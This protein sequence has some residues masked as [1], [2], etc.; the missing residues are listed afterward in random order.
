V[1]H[2]PT[3]GKSYSQD[4]R[5]ESMLGELLECDESSEIATRGCDPCV[6][7]SQGADKSRM[8]T[9][10]AQMSTLPGGLA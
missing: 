9:G 1:A 8:G 10:T 6:A 5:E 7:V 4:A 2:P 3:R